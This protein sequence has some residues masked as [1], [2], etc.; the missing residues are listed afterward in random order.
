ML[1]RYKEVA[2]LSVPFINFD[3]C[4]H[5]YTNIQNKI[6]DISNF[7]E[8]FLRIFFSYSSP[9]PLA[10][11]NHSLICFLPIL[12]EYMYVVTVCL[13]LVWL[14]ILSIIFLRYIH[15]LICIG[16]LFLCIEESYSFFFSVFII[17][18]LSNHL[19]KNIWVIGNF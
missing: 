19:L 18:C 14:L 9:L 10:A 16:I 8:S 7:Y 1:Y 15:I 6:K 13:L 4:I 3:S 2:I 5:P 11:G 12:D 17:F